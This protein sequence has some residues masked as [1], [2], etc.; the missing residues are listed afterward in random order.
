M[1]MDDFLEPLGLKRTDVQNWLARPSVELR[2]QYAETVRGSARRF[3]KMNVLELA[4]MNALVS[5]G[6]KLSDAVTWAEVL[7]DE[8]HRPCDAPNFLVC[9]AQEFDQGFLREELNG[10]DLNQLMHETSAVGLVVVDVGSVYRKVDQL[11][12][13]KYRQPSPQGENG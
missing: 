8:Y 2:T 10:E 11:F 7:I 13:T 9:P 3:S 1:V 6:C 12:R 5:V 4:L